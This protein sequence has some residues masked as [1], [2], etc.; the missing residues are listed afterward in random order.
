MT[1]PQ[2]GLY[3]HYKGG[4][5]LVLGTAHDAD[6]G[7]DRVVYVPLYPVEGAPLA[8]RRVSDFVGQVEGPDGPQPR[9]RYLG[10][11]GG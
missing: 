6:G 11:R 8:V 3:E 10:P 9:F 2:T 4:R 7:E 5:Y 1:D